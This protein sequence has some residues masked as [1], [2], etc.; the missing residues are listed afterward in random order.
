MLSPSSSLLHAVFL[1]FLASIVL[2]QYQSQSQSQLISS[3]AIY[4]SSDIRKLCFIIIPPPLL[5]LD[6]LCGILTWTPPGESVLVDNPP[7]FF[8]FLHFHT[9]NASA[10]DPVQGPFS[11]LPHVVIFT[12]AYMAVIVI[13]EKSLS[14][15]TP[16]FTPPYPPPHL[17][18]RKYDRGGY[19]FTM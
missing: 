13:F 10:M 19:Q 9:K 3:P 12:S 16:P 8:Y 4:S 14:Q 18:S 5:L 6:R 1:A 7:F 2:Y 15:S 11:R 17:I